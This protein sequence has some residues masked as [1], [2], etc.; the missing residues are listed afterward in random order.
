M[1]ATSPIA[2]ANA[3]RSTRGRFPVARWLLVVLLSTCPVAAQHETRADEIRAA[4]KDKADKLTPEA[5]YPIE[6]R[7]NALDR[8]RVIERLMVGGNGLG[9][10]LGGLPTGQGFALGPQYRRRDLAKGNLTFRTSA[11]ASL[12]KALLFDLQLTAPQLAGGKLFL[13]FYAMHRNS[14]RIDYFGPGPDSAVTDR[15]NFRLEENSY[16]FTVG[17]R[18]A[19]P[20]LLGVVGGWYQPNAGPGNR[21]E[22][23]APKTEAVFSEATT[24]GLTDQTSFLHGGVFVQFDYRD[25]PGTPRKGGNYVAKFVHY[26]DRDL[27]RHDHRRLELDAQQYF[28]FFNEKRVIALRARSVMT[29]ENGASVLPFYMQP[30]LGGSDDLRG[31]RQ[32][33]FYDNNLI[34]A[35]AEYRFEVFSGLD[36]TLFFDA[37]KVVPKRS[38]VNFHDLEAAVGFG[39]RF[40]I[41]NSVFMRI[42]TGFSHEG[43]QIWL[44]FGNVF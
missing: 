25:I 22:E 24:P 31:F 5:E 19:K 17:V 23:V 28:P 6:K 16:E 1:R 41:R 13:D 27:N 7:L 20:F 15:T 12:S 21:S 32:W 26:N 11:A 39:F 9:A 42:D 4:R 44:K 30:V 3:G 29:F 35:N 38:Q 8:D 10:R 34:V 2:I 43:T 33:R 37:G 36:M 18:P 40:N 14:P